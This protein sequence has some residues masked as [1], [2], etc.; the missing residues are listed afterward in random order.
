M[1]RKILKIL[2]L[3]LLIILILGIILAVLYFPTMKK[4]YYGNS[5]LHPD[6]ALTIYLGGGGNTVV[7]NTDSA[8]L[9]IDTKY[10]KAAESLYGRV[11]AL[12][13][14]KPVI[15]V[16]THSDLDHT[17]GNPLYKDASIISGRVDEEYWIVANKGKEGRPSVWVTDT[18]NLR[19]GNENVKLISVGQAHTWNDIVVCFQNRGLLVTGDLVFNGFNTFFDEKKG[20]NG[21]KSIDA[22]K[23]LAILPG[24]NTVVPGHGETGGVELI[25]QMLGYLE[26]MAMAADHPEKE[27]EIKKKYRKLAAMP[28]MSSTGIVIAYFRNNR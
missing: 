28:G 19:L 21:W 3:T 20:S 17:G 25:R 8:V 9:V 22:L 13:N 24:I 23:S 18:L 14:G 15:I 11:E 6:S 2:G 27:K 4:L 7:F 10:G 16:N 12:R 26:D 5:V 1:K